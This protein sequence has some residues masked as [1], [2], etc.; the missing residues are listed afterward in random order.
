[1]SSPSTLLRSDGA[2]LSLL[3]HSNAH[4]FQATIGGMGLTGIILSASLRLMRVHSLDITETA[5]PF[6]DLGEFFDAWPRAAD[7]ANEY[8]VAWID[9]SPGNGQVAARR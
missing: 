8:A 5:T 1:M 6:R 7:H 4:L 3:G 2:D 9:Q